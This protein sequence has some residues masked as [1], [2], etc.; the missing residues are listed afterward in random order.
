MATT[1]PDDAIDLMVDPDEA[2][3]L[4]S[5]E[6]DKEPPKKNGITKP[7]SQTKAGFS[8]VKDCIYDEKVEETTENRDDANKYK[9]DDDLAE[10]PVKPPR[11]VL[12]ENIQSFVDRRLCLW[13]LEFGTCKFSDA[14]CDYA[15]GIEPVDILLFIDVL[16][17]AKDRELPVYLRSKVFHDS[18]IDRLRKL[19]TKQQT[20]LAGKKLD[21]L[22]ALIQIAETTQTSAIDHKSDPEVVYTDW[23][24]TAK[25]L[26]LEVYVLYYKVIPEQ[27]QTGVGDDELQKLNILLGILIDLAHCISSRL[28]GE[29][30][31]ALK[32]AWDTLS[33]VMSSGLTLP[34]HKV[35]G[36]WDIFLNGDD[37]LRL[38]HFVNYLSV[39]PGYKLADAQRLNCTFKKLI[40]G[41][42]DAN[43]QDYVEIMFPTLLN[44]EKDLALQMELDVIQ[45]IL[46]KCLEHHKKSEDIESV[47]RLLRSFEIPGLQR[48]PEDDFFDESSGPSMTLQWQAY[49]K[50]TLDMGN[51]DDVAEKIA[52]L[53]PDDIFD[54]SDAFKRIFESI[55]SNFGDVKDMTDNAFKRL[56]EAMIKRN[57][58]RPLLPIQKALLSQFAAS[59]IF[60]FANAEGPSG[61]LETVVTCMSWNMRFDPWF[62]TT[63][64]DPLS[65][66]NAAS[67]RA[68]HL[69]HEVVMAGV[70]SCLVKPEFVMWGYELFRQNRAGICQNFP[71]DTVFR[72]AR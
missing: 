68:H 48:L 47:I 49:L 70:V 4:V 27:F 40:V 65:Y 30:S 16:R 61:S 44:I 71:K 3:D 18:K 52:E 45:D 1:E 14:K 35:L 25:F 38:L 54:M 33:F 51:W 20:V 37:N 10:K 56:V 31:T 13:K 39:F 50:H 43:C 66:S 41:Q 9:A 19:Y 26:I 69:P 2:F 55:V 21:C 28:E 63:Y 62:C 7:S 64:Y 17:N 22:T 53:E 24:K 60:H 5:D 15:H 32:L 42:L 34:I 46:D 8:P 57:K 12:P 36:L 29:T 11:E 59:M 67:L 72:L 6:D 23:A 58:G